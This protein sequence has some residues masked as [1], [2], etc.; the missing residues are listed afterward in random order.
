L[1]IINGYRKHIIFDLLKDKADLFY[2]KMLERKVL[3][4]KSVRPISELYE[5]CNG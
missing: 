2:T 3:E 1:K 4:E 5:I